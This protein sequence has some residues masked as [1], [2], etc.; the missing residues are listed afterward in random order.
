M[1]LVQ[2]ITLEMKCAQVLK[3]NKTHAPSSLNQEQEFAL[4]PP[5]S[6]YFRLRKTPR[7]PKRTQDL[8]D[9]CILVTGDLES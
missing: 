8:E 1:S 6:A 9:S 2:A 4:L 7:G 3:H 5:L